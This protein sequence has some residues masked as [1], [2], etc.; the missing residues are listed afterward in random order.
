M[1]ALEPIA[2]GSYKPFAL[3]EPARAQSVNHSE[4][5]ANSPRLGQIA[6]LD[7]VGAGGDSARQRLLTTQV[8]QVQVG[9]SKAALVGRTRRAVELENRNQSAMIEK[10][11][12]IWITS[13]LRQSLFQE[14]RIVLGLNERSDAVAQSDG[15]LGKAA[16]RG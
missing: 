12:T 16:E 2:R 15:T 4:N 10:V 6:D 5:P 3:Q 11:R 14:T 13:Y 1:P 8:K 9:G 7:L